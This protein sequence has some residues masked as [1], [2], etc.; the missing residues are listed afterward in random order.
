[1]L[2]LNF[3]DNMKL[4]NKLLIVG[5]LGLTILSLITIIIAINNS[6]IQNNLA[7]EKFESST[8]QSLDKAIS[9]QFYERYGD[10]QAF[11]V[12]SDLQEKNIQ[13]ITEVFNS[14]S[15]MYGIYDIILF[16]DTKGNYIASN[17]KNASGSAI[18]SSKLASK[19]YLQEDF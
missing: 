17:N 4:K 11:A 13:N 19:N 2:H 18:N 15:S 7:V 6:N 10:V 9:A 14:Y 1:M 12:N 5:T 3:L 8:I 16:V